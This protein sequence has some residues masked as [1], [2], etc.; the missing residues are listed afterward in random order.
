MKENLLSR[1]LMTE[2]LKGYMY[3]VFSV[4]IP[5]SVVLS[6]GEARSSC[7]FLLLLFDAAAKYLKF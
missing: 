2:R 5:F 6:E 4:Q 3:T 1:F 7:F